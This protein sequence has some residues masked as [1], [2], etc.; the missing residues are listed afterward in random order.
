M[1]SEVTFKVK[2]QSQTENTISICNLNTSEFQKSTLRGK[3]GTGAANAKRWISAAGRYEL[4]AY[5]WDMTDIV[6][7]AILKLLKNNSM[8][9][10]NHNYLSGCHQLLASIDF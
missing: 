5:L 3:L 6:T 1:T 9:T 4:H 7:S 2:V 10:N 8:P